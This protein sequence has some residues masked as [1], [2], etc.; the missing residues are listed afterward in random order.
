MVVLVTVGMTIDLAVG[1]TVVLIMVGLFVNGFRSQQ[2]LGASVG[3]LEEFAVDG[4]VQ[5]LIEPV[6]FHLNL[7]EVADLA[8]DREREA[9]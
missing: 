9:R 2:R 6:A 8:L 7:I 1:T 3:S 5:E 4:M